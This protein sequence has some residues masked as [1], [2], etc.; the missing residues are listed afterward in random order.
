MRASAMLFLIALIPFLA[1]DARACSICGCDPSSGTLGLDR[2]SA[3]DMR[4]AL[5]DRYFYKESGTGDAY[6]GERENRALFRLQY[7]PLN[8]LTVQVDLPFYAWKTHLDASGVVDDRAHGLGDVLIGAR[9]E[10]LRM[11]GLMPRHVLALVGTI[12]APSGAN[13]RG[14]P[15]VIDEHKQLGTGTWDEQ[16]GLWYTFGAF[17]TVG[18]AGVQAR[19]N[20]TNGRG[21]HYGNAL[22]A[23]V[24]ARRSFLESRRLYLSLDLQGRNAGYDHFADGSRDPDSGGFLTYAAASAG[25]A[26][27]DSFLLQGSLQIPAFQALHGTQSEHPVAFVGLAYDFPL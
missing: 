18:Y 19:V 22:F 23:T 5:E 21:F 10:L 1:R 14:T 20:G 17:P 3:G 27:T 16:V 26:I 6:E 8:R 4:L 15:G 9:Y 11:G 25:F 13:D 7:A 2:P 24:G 12:K